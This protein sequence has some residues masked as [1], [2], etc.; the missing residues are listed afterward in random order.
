MTFFISGKKSLSFSVLTFISSKTIS[1]LQLGV[2]VCISISY[3]LPAFGREIA[4]ITE[5]IPIL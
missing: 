4:A 2:S 5:I 1:Q 3:S